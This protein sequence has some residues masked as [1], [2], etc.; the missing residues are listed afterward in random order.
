MKVPKC[1]PCLSCLVVPIS[2]L[3]RM[4]NTVSSIENKII[5]FETRGKELEENE[6][7]QTS[8]AQSIFQTSN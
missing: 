3:D 4:N 6:N 8:I 1:L 7:K 5:A 2:I